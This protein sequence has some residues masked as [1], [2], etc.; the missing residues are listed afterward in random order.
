MSIEKFGGI[1]TPTCDICG[2]ELDGGFDFYDAVQA[3]KTAGWKSR[4][5]NGEW[6]DVCVTCQEDE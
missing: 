6:E 2:E 5:T 3:K 4:K 1:F